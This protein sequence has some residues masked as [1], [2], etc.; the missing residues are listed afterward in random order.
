M[1]WQ[2]Q[3]PGAPG[4]PAGTTTGGAGA[5]PYQAPAGL[6]VGGIR[7]NGLPPTVPTQFD[8]WLQGY[9]P[10]I[11]AMNATGADRTTQIAQGAKGIS[12]ALG[13]WGGDLSAFQNA[14]T[15][16]LGASALGAAGQ[17]FLNALDWNAIQN[18]ATNA[19][20]GGVSVLAQLQKAQADRQAS[21]ESDLASRGILGDISQ[22]KAV[23]GGQVY[24]GTT[25]NETQRAQEQYSEQQR[26]MQYLTGLSSAFAQSENQRAATINQAATDAQQYYLDPNNQIP[27]AANMSG[28]VGAGDPTA[29]PPTSAPPVVSPTSP[30]PAARQEAYRRRR[31]AAQAAAA[32]ARAAAQ[33]RA[34]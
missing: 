6:D 29:P 8:Q 34:G 33:R 16:T 9:Q 24:A 15:S 27:G 18:A 26:I 30:N 10:Y 13:M 23:T 4:A 3:V 7:V 25:A 12:D 22:P 14:L 17:G 11:N 32:R 28:P 19:N 31:A 5:A 21:L 1:Y 2:Q 20:Q